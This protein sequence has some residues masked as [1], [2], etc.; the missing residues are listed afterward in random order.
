MT[1][2]I[3]TQVSTKAARRWQGTQVQSAHQTATPLVQWFEEHTAFSGSENEPP[4]GSEPVKNILA[5]P[6]QIIGFTHKVRCFSAEMLAITSSCRG[7]RLFGWAL[8]SVECAVPPEKVQ[9]STA[10]CSVSLS[11]LSSLLF[12]VSPRPSPSEPCSDAETSR[13]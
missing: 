3:S 7:S 9:R 13:E 11:F 6:T 1:R 8:G 12:S 2:K 10:V 4:K 5:S